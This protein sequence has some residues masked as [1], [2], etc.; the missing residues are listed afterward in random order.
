MKMCLN[1][2]LIDC[3]DIVLVLCWFVYLFDSADRT[4]EWDL[5]ICLADSAG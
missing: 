5:S 4:M 3:I 1:L 2:C